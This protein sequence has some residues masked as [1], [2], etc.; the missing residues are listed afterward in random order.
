LNINIIIRM[1]FTSGA[2]S[3][4]ATISS[5]MQIL[6]RFTEYPDHD[7]HSAVIIMMMLAA[8]VQGETFRSLLRP[9]PPS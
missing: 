4:C 1:H 2:W 5:A 6:L 9:L 8:G 3:A 7:A